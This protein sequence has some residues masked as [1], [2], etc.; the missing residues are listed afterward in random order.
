[1]YVRLIVKG[2]EDNY[3]SSFRTDEFGQVLMIFFR[4]IESMIISRPLAISCSKFVEWRGDREN[5]IGVNS[6]MDICRYNTRYVYLKE[7]VQWQF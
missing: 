3:N 4:V 5:K 7:T 2:I 1:M 6:F